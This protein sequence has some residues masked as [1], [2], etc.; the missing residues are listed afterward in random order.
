MVGAVGRVL[1]VQVG[2]PVIREVLGHLAGGAG[3]PRS[4]VALHG[5]VEGIAA[6]NM[7]NVGRRETAW[8]TGRVKT[9]EGQSR[10]GEAQAGL[11]G[12]GHREGR[13]GPLHLGDGSF[14]SRRWVW[15]QRFGLVSRAI[16]R[17]L[18]GCKSKRGGE[19]QSC[20]RSTLISLVLARTPCIGSLD[21]C[22]EL[23]CIGS[24]SFPT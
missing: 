21:T 4:N 17:G 24:S 14:G 22:P 12:R 9:L 2:G 3:S 5:G 6:D 10:A 8:L 19:A 11:D 23:S 16:G 7:V 15:S 1:E 13:G 20:V 18:E